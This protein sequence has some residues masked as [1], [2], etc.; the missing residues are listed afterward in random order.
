MFQN[1]LLELLCLT[2]ME[3]PKENSSE[4]IRDEKI[5]VL[6]KIKSIDYEA[7]IVR[8]QYTRSENSKKT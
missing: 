5:K 2:A 7:H 4:S 8:G 6:K 3:E 1:H